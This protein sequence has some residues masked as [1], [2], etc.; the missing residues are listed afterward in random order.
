MIEQ[1]LIGNSCRAFGHFNNIKTN[2]DSE[3]GLGAGTLKQIFILDE[4]MEIIILKCLLLK[5]S[6]F[7][8]L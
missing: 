1:L 3:T 5:Y 4:K 2:V 6:F 8:Q 7:F